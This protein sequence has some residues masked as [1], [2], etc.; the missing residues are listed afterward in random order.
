[1]TRLVRRRGSSP[2]RQRRSALASGQPLDRLIGLD[3][4]AH[5]LRHLVDKVLAPAVAQHVQRLVADDGIKPGLGGGRGPDRSGGRSARSSHRPPARPPRRVRGASRCAARRRSL[6][7]IRT[8]RSPAGPLFRPG[9]SGPG[10]P[11]DRWR[12]MPWSLPRPCCPSALHGRMRVWM[13][14]RTAQTRAIPQMQA[15]AASEWSHPVYRIWADAPSARGPEDCA[16]R[17][18]TAPG[19]GL[20]ANA[21]AVSALRRPRSAARDSGRGNRPRRSP[22]P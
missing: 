16:S 19:D 4:G 5:I 17:R 2:S 20:C 9:R 14:A 12:Q 8:R 15:V 7:G 18:V 21:E 22:P 10:R 13:Q 6:P 1:M 11:S 3:G